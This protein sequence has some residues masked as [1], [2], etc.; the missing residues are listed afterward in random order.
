MI[1]ILF[2]CLGNICRSP[3]AEAVFMEK[4]RK[5]GLQDALMADSAGT[6][7]WH[8]GNPPDP[9]SIAVAEKNN[10]PISHIG[11]QFSSDDSLF[12]YILAMDSDN[13]ATILEVLRAQHEGLLLMRHFDPKEKGADVP[14]PYYCGEDGFQNVYD[15][16]DRSCDQLI[17]YLLEKHNL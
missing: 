13:L 8:V 15:I 16:L 1:K 10:I 9:R 17:E 2:V 12:D 6:G 5:K 7:H 14:D 4:V 3:L 11:R